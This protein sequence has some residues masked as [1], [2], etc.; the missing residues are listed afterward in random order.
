QSAQPFIVSTH[1]ASAPVKSV[2]P[3]QYFADAAGS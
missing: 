2:Q 1:Q 3:Q